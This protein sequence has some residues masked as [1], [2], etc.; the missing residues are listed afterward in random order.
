M[1]NIIGPDDGELVKLKNLSKKLNLED[2][3]NFK[4]PIYGEQRFSWIKILTL[5]Y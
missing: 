4:A 1:L 5:F 2:K 3:V